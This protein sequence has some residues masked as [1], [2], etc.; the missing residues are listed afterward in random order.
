ML[1]AGCRSDPPPRYNLLL[2]SIDTVRQD[3]L[4]CYGHVPRRAPGVSTSPHLDALAAAGVRM[5]DAYASSSWTLPSHISMMTG[6]TPVV[7]G[8]DTDQQA[9]AGPEPTLAELLGRH[10][11]RTAGVFSGPYLE[12]MWGFGRGFERYRAA[13]GPAA[14]AARVEA[15]EGRVAAADHVE[16]RWLHDVSSGEVTRSAIEELRE[17]A[18]QDRPW[19]L[20]AHY[21]DAHED[22]VPPRPYADRFDP[23][24]AGA[25]TGKHV[26]ANPL[27]S[28]RR[29]DDRDEFI[30][31]AS[32][33][34][35]EHVIALYEGEIAWV[36][37]HVGTVLRELDALG[38]ADRTLVIV[39][40]DHGEEFFE[41]GG[42]GHHRTLEDEVVR[43][44]LLLRLPGVLP[45]GRSVRGPVSTADL[46]PTILDLFAVPDGKTW[47]GARSFVPLIEGREDAAER[48]ILT[49]LVTFKAGTANID[50]EPPIP[51]R[52]VIVA[53]RYR[54]GAI[55]I[56]RTRSWPQFGTAPAA[57]RAALEDAGERQFRSERLTWTGPDRPEPSTAFDDPAAGAALAAMQ[58]EYRAL[59]AARR[60]AAA[61]RLSGSVQAALGAL[62]YVGDAAPS[63]GL[64]LSL[65]VPGDR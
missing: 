32:E 43:I 2:V 59:L 11:Y 1:I 28:V 61:A 34:D 50:G 18:H 26:L 27:V 13:Y 55:D 36:D 41:H 31:T 30:R 44:P 54:R 49:R 53:E 38:V 46:L 65:P 52:H 14:T 12:P 4:G 3:F 42:L 24:Y 10:G 45:A 23:T 62:G 64:D 8:V 47:A 40:S 19:F 15:L 29:P 58:T 37:E 33:R 63:A 56:R 21:F 39:V 17:L 60:S 9:L 7:H 5:A 57:V 6:Q 25:V 22:Y 35:L 16:T 51:T 48:S 20:F